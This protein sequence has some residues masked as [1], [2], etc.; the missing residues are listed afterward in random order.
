MFA[1]DGLKQNP[2]YGYLPILKV[3]TAGRD[4]EAAKY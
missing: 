1:T 3:P 2:P 4:C